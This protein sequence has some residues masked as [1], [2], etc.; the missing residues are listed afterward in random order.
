MSTDYELF[1]GKQLSDLFNDIYTNQ[2]NKK[3]K[4]SSFIDE[5]KGMVRH[6]GDIAVIGP[7][8]QDLIESSVKNDEHLL[9]LAQIAQRMIAAETKNVEDEGILTERDKEQLLKDLDE[10][11]D[12]SLEEDKKV[13]KLKTKAAD[14][15]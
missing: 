2:I 5:L 8:I 3:K 4:I 6:A 11:K 13:K 14:N 1:K 7:V 10:L 9:K 15:N 12:K